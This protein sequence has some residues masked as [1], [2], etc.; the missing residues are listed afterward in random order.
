[1]CPGRE[2]KDLASALIDPKDNFG[3]TMNEDYVDGAI[4]NYIALRKTINPEFNQDF[5]QMRREVYGMLVV[6]SLK[7]AF[8]KVGYDSKLTE[9]LIAIAS[10]YAHLYEKSS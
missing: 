6:E 8:Y 5:N 1:M 4:K 3:K 7:Q 9:G 2:S 10:R